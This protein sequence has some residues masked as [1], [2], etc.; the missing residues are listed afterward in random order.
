MLSENRL[1]SPENENA[2]LKTLGT[3]G[4]QT[5]ASTIKCRTSTPCATTTNLAIVS[6]HSLEILLLS[7]SILFCVH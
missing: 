4:F 3:F 6:S 1:T 2:N 7:S 5:R